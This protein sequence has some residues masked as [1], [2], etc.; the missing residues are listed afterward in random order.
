MTATPTHAIRRTL[1]GLE[2]RALMAAALTATLSGGLLRVEGTDRADRIIVR[3]QNGRIW[4]DNA[5][6]TYNG[7]RY[8]WAYAGAVTRV[9]V[10][11]LGGDDRIYLNAP[12]QAVTK[13]TLIDG[14][15]GN[16]LAAGGR[17]NNYLF[18]GA[19]DDSL[20]GSSGV[21]LFDGGA[22]FDRYWDAFDLA[23]P[24]F[25][26][27]DVRDIRQGDMLTCQ[28]LGVL[29]AMV[30]NGVDYGRMITY[31]GGTAFDVSLRGGTVTER[32]D[33][34]GTWNDNDPQPAGGAPEFWTILLQRARLQ[35][36]D[37]PYD[38]AMS[39]SEQQWYFDRATEP[40]G[41]SRLAFDTLGLSAYDFI[42][43]WPP[44]GFELTGS[45]D[46]TQAARLQSDL[47]DRW[48]MTLSSYAHPGGDTSVNAYGVV[49]HHVYALG[50]V[51]QDAGGWKFRV[52]DPYGRDSFG[53][54]DG[55][56]DGYL[57]LTLEQFRA[58]F[59]AIALF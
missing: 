14:G 44:R 7:L 19:G 23:R 36:W 31:R 58:S 29:A 22:G 24:V 52:Y 2:D 5:K 46:E 33:F 42:G 59:K 53:T 3:E 8:G 21:D 38:H 20:Y 11:A 40:Y 37:I 56:D 26:G 54:R 16:D 45:F 57:T 28:T 13:A 4:V 27:C 12:G 10:R 48:S 18:G 55:A 43:H 25:N 32:V 30:R 17:G 41:G 34:N 51:Y 9:E 49:Y 6:I 50:D 39:D 15:S 47:R 35:F 1:E